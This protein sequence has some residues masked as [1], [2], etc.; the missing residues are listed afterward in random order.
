M[1]RSVDVDIAGVYDHAKYVS[2]LVRDAPISPLLARSPLSI[3]PPLFILVSVS[4]RLY[5]QPS[6][7][8]SMLFRECKLLCY[9][10]KP[11]DSFRQRIRIAS[12]YTRFRLLI[13]D[14]HVERYFVEGSTRGIN[15]RQ[16]HETRRRGASGYSSW[17]RAS[18][19]LEFFAIRLFVHTQGY[20]RA[21]ASFA[22]SCAAVE[23]TN[24]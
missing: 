22:P 1:A 3:R 18:S 14:F 11:A 17:S 20:I 21:A 5:E 15:L 2:Y 4:S 24:S 6:S 8:V 23:R 7:S 12:I 9:R 10:V 19:F 16:R 13:R